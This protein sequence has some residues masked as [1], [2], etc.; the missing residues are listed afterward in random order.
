M[1]VYNFCIQFY[2]GETSYL[3]WGVGGGVLRVLRLKWDFCAGLRFLLA[4][5]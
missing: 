1:V 4:A 5:I 2:K 3:F